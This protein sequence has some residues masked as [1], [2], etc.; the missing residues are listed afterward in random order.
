MKA[1][2]TT[3]RVRYEE[4]DRMG[5]AYYGNYLTW[6]EVARTELFRERGLP[7]TALEAQGMRLV[8][9][10]AQCTYK[11]PVTYDDLLT[12][13][14]QIIDKKNTSLTFSYQI[15]RETT[16]VATGKTTHVFT[17]NKGKPIRIPERVKE[18]LNVS[19]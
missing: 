3:I 6:F 15:Y 9:V 1:Y 13:L 11:A 16:L 4:T 2:K 5:V 12:L 7:Y 14:T 17:D 18:V 10:D 19:A 8:V